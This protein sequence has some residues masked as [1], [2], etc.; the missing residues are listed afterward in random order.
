[1]R[2]I[3][4]RP[5]PEGRRLFGFFRRQNSTNS[6]GVQVTCVTRKKVQWEA[7]AGVI[8]GLPATPGP[9]RRQARPNSPSQEKRSPVLRGSARGD[10]HR[11]RGENHVPRPKPRTH[12]P[13]LQTAE[14]TGGPTASRAKAGRAKNQKKARALLDQGFA[15]RAQS[16]EGPKQVRGRPD[17]DPKKVRK[18]PKEGPKQVQRRLEEGPKKASRPAGQK[19]SSEACQKA[20]RP[21]ARHARR[22]K[23]QKRGMPE[24]QEARSEA[25]QKTKRPKTRHARRPGEQGQRARRTRPAGT[26]KTTLLAGTG[27]TTWTGKITCWRPSQRKG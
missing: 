16:K 20:Q 26:E 21:D 8:V 13:C 10:L 5:R 11:V 24:G 17:E 23:G 4:G 18:R 14:I 9:V 3:V 6:L 27:K 1:M 15:R 22:H 25:C 2:K 19:A 7:E 12:H